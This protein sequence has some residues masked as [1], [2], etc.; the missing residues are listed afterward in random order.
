MMP[1]IGTKFYENILNNYEVIEWIQLTYLILQRSIILLKHIGG[2][3]VF[4]QCTPTVV[5]A[6]LHL[7]QVS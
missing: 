1:D 7:Y 2:A 5:D 6:A 3:M 4:V